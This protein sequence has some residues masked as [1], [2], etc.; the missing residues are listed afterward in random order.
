LIYITHKKKESRAMKNYNEEEV[1]TALFRKGCR[2][3]KHNNRLLEVPK[4]SL[5]NKMLGKLDFLI[6]YRG[7]YFVHV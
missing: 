6:N 5:G 4:N 7:W 2:V 3:N 1:L